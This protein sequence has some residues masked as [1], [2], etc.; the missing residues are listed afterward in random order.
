MISL[1]VR[2]EGVISPPSTIYYPRAS[3]NF[4]HTRKIALA[5]QQQAEPTIKFLGRVYHAPI[6]VPNSPTY[7]VSSPSRHP[8]GGK[9]FRRNVWYVTC[10][11]AW[12]FALGQNTG[13]KIMGFPENWRWSWKRGLWGGVWCWKEKYQ[14]KQKKKSF[15]GGNRF[16]ISH[17]HPY[18]PNV[19]A[20]FEIVWSFL[21]SFVRA[22][23]LN[24]SPFIK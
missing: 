24:H 19:W 12:W 14:G 15:Y 8:L 17:E 22:I 1:E 13:E 21:S 4:P 20:V 23:D 11:L 16:V 6:T 2:I 3:A 5:Q 9:K 7:T 18:L 10:L